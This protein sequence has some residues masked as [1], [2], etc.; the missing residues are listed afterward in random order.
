MP[1]RTISTKQASSVKDIA[2]KGNLSLLGINTMLEKD[3]RKSEM[4]AG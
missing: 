1:N 3:T 2:S 4:V